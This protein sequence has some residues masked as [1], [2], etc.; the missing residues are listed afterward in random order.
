MVYYV[1][2]AETRDSKYVAKNKMKKVTDYKNLIL[3]QQFQFR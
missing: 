3:Q 1:S 2:D